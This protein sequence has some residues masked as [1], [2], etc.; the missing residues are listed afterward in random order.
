MAKIDKSK[1]MVDEIERAFAELEAQGVAFDGK[2]GSGDLPSGAESRQSTGA[3]LYLSL[4]EIEPDPEQPRKSF[5]GDQETGNSLES[6]RDSIIQHGVLQPIS[7]RRTDSGKYR[8]IAGERRWR[9]SCLAH[10][11]GTACQRAGYD[12]SRIPAVI[13]EPVDDADRLE[14][15]LVE[16]LARADMPAIDTARALDRLRSCMDPS[17]SM[18][19]LGKRLGRS[20]AWVHQMLSLVS[21]EARE[22]TEI[23]GVPVES[24][25]RT[26]L[27]RMCG[28]LKDDAKR[29]VLEAIRARM[30]AGDPLTR[31]L[32]DEEEER[33]EQSRRAA[34][35]SLP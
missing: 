10:E 22:V 26:D 6:L 14:M 23:L 20:K 5:S 9:A 7:V 11:S 34:A 18:E 35:T 12:L 24:I 29:Q 31:V 16:N 13:L 2:D 19:E 28:W 21:P 27:S 15:Q 17:P 33:F 1:T 25:G 30:D 32:V 4:T 3:S 8:I